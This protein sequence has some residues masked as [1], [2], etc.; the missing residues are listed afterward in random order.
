MKSVWSM[1]RLEQVPNTHTKKP[2]ADG[3]FFV[4]LVFA[5]ARGITDL[6]DQATA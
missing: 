4:V 3:G 1:E 6:S 2:P 5:P